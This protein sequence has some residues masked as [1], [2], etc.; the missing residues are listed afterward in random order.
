MGTLSSHVAVL[1]PI[2]RDKFSDAFF[3]S[4]GNEIL[5]KLS[6]EKLM[7]EVSYRRG[8]VV[9]NNYWITPPSNYRHTARLCNPEDYNTEFP[10]IETDGKIMLTN[11]KITEE[12]DPDTVDTFSDFALDSIVV[13]IDGLEEGAYVD[14]LLV[15]TSGTLANETIIISGNDESSGGTT[16]LYFQHRATSLLDAAKITGATIVQPD[17]YL[18]IF[19]FGSYQKFTAISDEVPIYDD[20]EIRIM[21]AGLM[22]KCS[23]RLLGAND[24]KTAEWERKYKEVV[25]EL[26]N[27]LLSKPVNVKA[28]GWAGLT[29]DSD[30]DGYAEGEHGK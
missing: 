16:K 27:E 30:L 3:I 29:D 26:R 13:N 7:R 8:V 25:Q 24:K 22:F 6:G 17:Y 15:I 20:F 28:R 18:I 14:H 2:Y 19:Y 9:T 21:N 4:K 5:E 11:N 12:I 1:P 10:F 23:E